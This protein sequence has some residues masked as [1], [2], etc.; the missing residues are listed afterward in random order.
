MRRGADIS[1]TAHTGHSEDSHSPEEW[2]RTVVK[3]IHPASASIA[4]V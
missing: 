2:A 3:R 1:P 4:V